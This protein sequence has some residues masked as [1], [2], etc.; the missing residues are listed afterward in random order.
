MT[1]RDRLKINRA[2][3][4]K[5]VKEDLRAL[6]KQNHTMQLKWLNKGADWMYQKSISLVPYKTGELQDGIQIDVS[7]SPRY[8]GII[9]I[10]T[11]KNSKTNFDYALIQEE[12]EEYKHKLGRQAHYLEEPFRQFVNAFFKH[13]GWN[14]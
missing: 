9:A 6:L 10:A 8:P 7:E 14:K 11:A 12:N 4:L 3:G 1:R 2:T 5:E 13:M